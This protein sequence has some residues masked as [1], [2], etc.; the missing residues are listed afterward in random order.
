MSTTDVKK[1]GFWTRALNYGN[2]VIPNTMKGGVLGIISN[3]K[4]TLS[5]LV[6]AMTMVGLELLLNAKVFDCPLKNHVCYG[7]MFLVGP[8]CIIFVVNLL[9]VGRIWTLSNR[10]C[11]KE[12]RRKGE[13]FF[14]VF[15]N[16]VKAMVGGLA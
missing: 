7:L 14:Y 4:V 5:H 8:P 15:P 11:V 10:C 9:I 16:A 3:N 12:Y 1:E 6:V 2:T 13:C